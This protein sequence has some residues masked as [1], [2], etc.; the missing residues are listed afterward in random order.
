MKKDLLFKEKT[1]SLL[2]ICT[3]CYRIYLFIDR[4]LCLTFLILKLLQNRKGSKIV[5]TTI[6]K[7]ETP[8]SFQIKNKDPEKPH[9]DGDDNEIE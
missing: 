2:P 3:L 4:R 9:S 6:K 7:A 1:T 5:S 8:F